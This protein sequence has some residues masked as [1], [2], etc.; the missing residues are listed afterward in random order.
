MLPDHSEASLGATMCLLYIHMFEAQVARNV[1]T[2]IFMWVLGRW[3][4]HLS[5]GFHFTLG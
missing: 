2:T 1:V 4:K 3:V 5:V